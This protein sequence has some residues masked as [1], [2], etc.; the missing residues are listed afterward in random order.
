MDPAFLSAVAGALWRVGFPTRASAMDL[1]F[2]EA[3]PQDVRH[4]SDKAAFY[5]PFVNHY[6]RAFIDSWDGTGVEDRLVNA[7]AL[8]ECWNQDRVDARSYPL[9]QAAWLA[10]ND[11]ARDTP[12]QAPV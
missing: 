7:S 12:H 11:C 2:G 9:L 4:R 8:R 3:L 10:T 5:A 1:L 6:S